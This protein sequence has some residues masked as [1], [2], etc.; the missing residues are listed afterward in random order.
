MNRKN[1]CCCRICRQR[2]QL[3]EP[4]A[5]CFRPRILWAVLA[6]PSWPRQSQLPRCHCSLRAVVPL[7]DALPYL[8]I[9]TSMLGWLCPLQCKRCL[10]CLRGLRAIEC[11]ITCCVP[12]QFYV[13]VYSCSAVPL[14]VAAV[15]FLH[16]TARDDGCLFVV[17]N[18]G[19]PYLEP[20]VWFAPVCVLSVQVPSRT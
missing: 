12:Q 10:C 16:G 2:A 13:Q 7:S 15:C 20:A 19:G 8:D 9:V 14:G 5:L 1:M 18:T 6:G 17:H 11:C 3:L 4:S